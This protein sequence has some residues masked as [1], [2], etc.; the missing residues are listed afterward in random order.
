ME[1]VLLYSVMIMV[2]ILLNYFLNKKNKKN[3]Q[4]VEDII[5]N[6]CTIK[7]ERKEVVGDVFIAYYFSFNTV[8]F[9]F[10]FNRCNLVL[11]EDAL[12]IFGWHKTK[13]Y[14]QKSRPMIIT[15]A[16]EKYEKLFPM[17]YITA[18]K[19]ANYYTNSN[20]VYFE[21][22]DL[23]KSPRFSADM[24]LYRLDKEFRKEIIKSLEKNDLAG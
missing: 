7:G 13:L 4:F 19:K 1:I 20:S 18:Y 24:H 14:T 15:F 6:H 23:E 22:G 10:T 12:V 11:L 21:I 3:H 5:A 9:D 17:A 16:K 2:F 8:S